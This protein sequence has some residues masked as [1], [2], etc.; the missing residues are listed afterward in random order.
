MNKQLQGVAVAA[1]TLIA[2]LMVNVNYLQAGQAESLRTHPR[3]GRQF[4]K[5]FDIDRGAIVIGGENIAYSHPTGKQLKFERRYREGALYSAVTGH[6]TAYAKTGVEKSEDGLL[7]G[8][9]QRLAV[10]RFLDI[11]TG[12]PS[13]GAHVELTV[14]PKAQQVAFRGVRSGTNTGRGAAVAIEPSTGK[15]LAMVSIPSYDPNA[16]ST[17]DF[18]RADQAAKQLQLQDGNPLLNKAMNERF[19]P[20]ST[21]K[22]IVAAAALE[23]GKFNKDTDVP[24]PSTYTPRGAGAPLPNSHEG[25]ACGGLGRAPL[26]NAFAESCNT[27]FAILTNDDL[28]TKAVAEQARKFGFGRE[29]PVGPG[30]ESAVSQFPDDADPALSALAAIGQGDTNATPLQMAMVASGIANEGKVMRPYLVDKIKAP[31]TSELGETEPEVLSEAMSPDNADQLKQMMQAV[32]TNGTAR[33]AISGAGSGG[34]KTGTAETGR[35]FNERWFIGF[36][37]YD[38]PKVAVAV[39]T[40]GPGSGG[41]NAAPIA[42]EIMQAVVNR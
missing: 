10:R 41:E 26:I 28:G 14:D 33:G 6:M 29:V 27:T 13:K 22:A 1:L 2:I 34:G 31:N 38:D 18:E 40:E 36:A 37:P 5:Q 16:I 39:V 23:S 7:N 12:K 19:P 8:T 30:N 42:N 4:N 35:G 20:G 32:V 25:G 3:N 17:N 11:L 24:A 15:I 21:Y 9:D